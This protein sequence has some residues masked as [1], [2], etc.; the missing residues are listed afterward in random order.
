MGAT[1]WMALVVAAVLSASACSSGEGS[2]GNAGGEGAAGATT[3]EAVRVV[4]QNILHGIACPPAS[5]N[6]ALP[7]RIDLFV[8]QLA[9]ADCPELA[10]LQEANEGIADL[11]TKRLPD[12]CGGRYHLVHDADAGLDREVVLTTDKVLGA[13][14]ERL[15]GPLRTALLVRVATKAGIVDLFTTHL[16]SSS[17]DRPCDAATCPAPCLPD[18]MLN[19]CQARQVLRLVDDLADPNAVVVVAGD[20]NAKPG[21]PTYVLFRDGGYVDTHLAAGNA[22]CDPATGKE[23]TSGRVDDNLSD[24]RDPTSKQT[25]RIDYV[26]LGGKRNCRV[27]EPTGLFNAAPA[28]DGPAGL[29]FP[30][31]HTGVQAT[32]RCATSDAQRQAATTATLATTSTTAPGPA[33]TADT[34]T[35]AAITQA[36]RNLF[37]GDVTDIDTKLASLED[38]DLLRPYFLDTY[39]KTRS[40]AANIRVRIDSITLTDATHADVVYTLRLGRTV[41][42][43]H[44]PGAAVQLDGRWLVSRR[45]YCEVSTQGATEIPA[46][47]RR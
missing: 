38:A 5:D 19:A 17:D 28:V 30:S 14:R 15:A 13:R 10:G 16:A 8:R 26:W 24:L 1:K 43:D 31:D 33:G 40:V 4:S 42:L 2:N 25:E 34:A 47:C 7:R 45:T 41:V 46:P 32:L 18:D 21:E 36:F 20:F 35:T 29:A 27:A 44:L 39:A 6:C 22:E 37:D 12:I 23:C 3:R 9:A 11:L